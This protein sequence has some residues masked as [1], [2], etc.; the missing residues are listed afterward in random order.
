MIL[1][2]LDLLLLDGSYLEMDQVIWSGMMLRKRKFS[3]TLTR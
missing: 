2:E 3:F 1:T